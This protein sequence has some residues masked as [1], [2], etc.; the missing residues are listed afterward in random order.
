[1]PT[2]NFALQNVPL[3]RRPMDLEFEKLP[4][5]KFTCRSERNYCE[6]PKSWSCFKGLCQL[7]S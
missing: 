4:Q 1:M 7:L 2:L 3:A 5:K 6:E